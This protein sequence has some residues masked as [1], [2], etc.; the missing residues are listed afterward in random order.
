M[1]IAA[2][3]GKLRPLL[4]EPERHLE[5]IASL[6]QEYQD[7]PECEV[8][9][10]WAGP[11]LRP[12][13]ERQLAAPEALHRARAVRLIRHLLGRSEAARLLRVAAI[14]PHLQVR[15]A[16]VGAARRM[17]LPDVV[18]SFS[19]QPTAASSRGTRWN[20]FWQWYGGSLWQRTRHEN[21]SSQ[22]RALTAQ[23]RAHFP[24]SQQKMNED[25]GIEKDVGLLRLQ[26]AGAGVGAPYV[27]FRIPKATGG[28][29]EI[30]APR[31]PLRAVQR[32]ILERYLMPFAP[33]DACH[34]FTRGRSV[35]T[36]A[37]PHVQAA[38]VLKTDIR[39]FFPG[40][41][42]HR[43]L[44]LF[45]L[46]GAPDWAACTL[47]SLT[48]YRPLLPDGS[49]AWPSVLPQGA[50]TSPALANLVCRRLDARLSGLAR[51]MEAHYTRYA[52]DLTFSFPR[53]P[54]DVGRVFWWI[55]SILQQEGFLENV[56]KRKV[57][58][59]SQRQQVTGVVVNE[60]CRIPREERRNFR[61]LLANC[62]RHGVASQAR[63][64]EDFEAYL[65]GY[66]AYARMVQ[67]ELG[68]PWWE[69]VRALLGAAEE[70]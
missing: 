7:D 50:P 11:A 46:L 29:R 44:G 68:G 18:P 20:G 17:G 53:E 55:N 3:L 5:A 45:V 27:L 58:R 52:D 64:R 13:I 69:R 62:E 63:G 48:T 47:A 49:V 35:V 12:V 43:V 42:Y 2:A 10:A 23:G 57:L 60:G 30:C 21:R 9:R 19:P 40:I 32:R 6:L 24:L 67:P 16:S 61:A 4:E 28:E 59:R 36:N 15:K 41:H 25:L 34:G 39:N 70:A 1:D 33:H 38:L 66:A 14:D 54:A 22:A 37:R 56:G 65:L 8:L 31:P 51:S 26:R